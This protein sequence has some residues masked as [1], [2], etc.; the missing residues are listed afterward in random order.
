[1]EILRL[2]ALILPSNNFMFVGDLLVIIVC[3][4]AVW[5]VFYMLTCL[6]DIY[7]VSVC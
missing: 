4:R 6:H 3:Q 1:M 2:L 5:L 7:I